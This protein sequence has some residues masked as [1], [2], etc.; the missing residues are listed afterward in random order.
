MRQAELKL[1]EKPKRTLPVLTVFYHGKKVVKRIRSAYPLNAASNLVPH[2]RRN[3]YGADTAEVYSTANG[4]LYAVM[5]RS[6]DGNLR[7]VF[8]AEYKPS[9][10]PPSHRKKGE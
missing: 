4:K 7:T 1:V 8:E 10:E 2:M 5:R 3:S 6:V 9:E